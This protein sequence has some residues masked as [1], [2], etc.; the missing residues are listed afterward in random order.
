[1]SIELAD[2]LDRVNAASPWHRNIHDDDIR[3]LGFVALICRCGVGGLTNDRYPFVLCKERTVAFAN[4]GVVVDNKDADCLAAHCATL[5]G[6][7]NGIIA[8]ILKPLSPRSMIS[9]CPPRAMTRSRMPISPN[10][11]PCATMPLSAAPH[12]SFSIVSVSQRRSDAV[13]S[14]T[15]GR[16]LR[17]TRA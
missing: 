5:T 17:S 15:S 6:I 4:D 8:W 14:P 10:P 2:M 12:P 13:G 9:N 1:M 11:L 7:S 3:P 16:K